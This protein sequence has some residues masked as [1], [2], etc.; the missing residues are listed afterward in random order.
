MDP[1]GKNAWTKQIFVGRKD[2]K[3]VGY[4]NVSAVET[5]TMKR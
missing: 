5:D 4:C 1:R 2:L 3:D